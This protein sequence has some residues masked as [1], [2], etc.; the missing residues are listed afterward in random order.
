V[1]AVGID[2]GTTCG[3]AAVS[4]ST[5]AWVTVSLPSWRRSVY[6]LDGHAYSRDVI[7]SAIRDVVGLLP[8]HANGL[9]QIASLVAIE[10]SQHAASMRAA[11]VQAEHLCLCADAGHHVTGRV[12]PVHPATWQH[13]LVGKLG[14]DEYVR[15]AVELTGG[16]LDP[17]EHD[18][19]A[20]ICIAEWAW[21]HVVRRSQ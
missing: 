1:I 20:A 2:P 21:Q 14:R 4:A 18:A 9:G 13:G 16:E 12:V 7:R 11:A 6:G 8:E 3:V 17:R 15:Y 19:A 5:A 10:D